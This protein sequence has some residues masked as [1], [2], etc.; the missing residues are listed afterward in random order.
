MKILGIEFAPL[1]IPLSRRIQ[2]LCCFQWVLTFIFGGFGCLFV[3]I[4][5]LFTRLW[6]V[7]PLY[8]C[9]YMYDINTANTGAR[10]LEVVRRSFIWKYMAD[11][12]PATLHKTADFNPKRSYILGLHPHGILQASGFLSFATE[13]TGFSEKFPGMT[14]HLTILSGH[15]KFPFYRDYLLTSGK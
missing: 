3:A 5:L 1:N 4:F 12:Y 11:Y 9:W 6:W 14:S 8:L 10:P 15:F 13:A 7:M 2:T